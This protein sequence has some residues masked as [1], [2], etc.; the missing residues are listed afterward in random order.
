MAESKHAAVEVVDESDTV[1]NLSKPLPN[2]ADKL[3]FDFDKINGYTLIACEK[4]AKKDDNTIM[5]PSLSQV[6][7]AYVAAA[8]A[9]VKVDLLVRGNCSLV[10]NQPHLGGNMRINAIIDRYLEHSRILIFANGA[11]IDHPEIVEVDGSHHDY[12]VFFGSADWM[13]RNL[14]K[15]VEIMFPIERPEL[16]KKLMNTNSNTN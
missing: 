11:D 7:Q 6:Y 8:A 9:G 3:V 4:K 16:Q 15:R 5:V 14:D 12:L 10:S 13:P 1:L 2:G